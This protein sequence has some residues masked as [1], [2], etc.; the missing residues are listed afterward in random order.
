MIE[1]HGL[2]LLAATAQGIGGPQEAL[3]QSLLMAF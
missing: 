3:L 1:K 2:C